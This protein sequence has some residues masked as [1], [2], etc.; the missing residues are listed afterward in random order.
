MAKKSISED[1][2]VPMD[3]I[4]V[5]HRNPVAMAAFVELSADEKLEYVH[6]VEELKQPEAR[7]Q[8]IQEVIDKLAPTGR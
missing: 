6:Y 8:R 2:T 1:R 5:L 3:F 4:Q 7:K